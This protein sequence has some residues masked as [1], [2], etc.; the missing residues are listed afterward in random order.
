MRK[1]DKK[2]DNEL[3]KALI[4]TCDFALHNIVGYKW[5]T[6]TVNYNE[7]PGSLIITC[8]FEDKKDAE[9]AFQQGDLSSLIKK[10]LN[11]ISIVLNKVNKQIRFEFQ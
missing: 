4:D 5:I 6:H 11:D 9:N 10:N 7:F 8:M 3:R 2:R 1:T